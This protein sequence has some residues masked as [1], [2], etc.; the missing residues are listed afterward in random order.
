MGKL[1]TRLVLF[2]SCLILFC[3]TG[4][5]NLYPKE[6][7]TD[8]LVKLKRDGT[9]KIK[10]KELTT[11][12][13]G[14]ESLGSTSF[15][16]IKLNNR[17]S[18]DP[19]YKAEVT[20]PNADE[21][22]ATPVSSRQK[23]AE[24]LGD[25]NR[26]IEAVKSASQKVQELGSYKD[27][28]TRKE[29]ELPFGISREVGGKEYTIIIDSI[30]LTPRYAYA[31]IY[32]EIEDPENGKDLY[33]AARD[34]RFT[35]DGGF[36]G[37]AELYLLK[38]YKIDL[39]E[40][41]ALEF[42]SSVSRSCYVKFNCDGFQEL[43]VEA[44][45][46][47][48]P[49]HFIQEMPNSPSYPEGVSAN[50]KKK[51]D[52]RFKEI[53]N[54]SV[55]DDYPDDNDFVLNDLDT[56]KRQFSLDLVGFEDL[57][58]SIEDLPNF[59]VKGLKDF[60]FDVGT[61]VLDFSSYKHQENTGV[62]DDYDHPKL[63]AD[64]TLW[65]GVILTDLEVTLPDALNKNKEYSVGEKERIS[66]GVRGLIVDNLG[67]TGEV[68]GKN[69]IQAGE[70]DLEGWAF[71]LEELAVSFKHSQWKYA[72]FNGM[73][74][75]PITREGLDDFNYA[76]IISKDNGISLTVSTE[77]EVEFELFKAAEVKLDTNSSVTLTYQNRK[78]IPS[79]NLNG[80]F[81]IRTQVKKNED[82]NMDAEEGKGFKLPEVTF[83]NLTLTSQ[84]PF[85]T[86][87]TFGLGDA[88]SLAGLP[89]T[90]TKFE[91]KEAP[92]EKVA[93]NITLSVNLMKSDE[94]G[95][96]ASG[97]LDIVAGI[98]PNR[99]IA[100]YKLEEVR[101]NELELLADNK[102]F[103]LKGK[104]QFFRGDETYG[105][106]FNSELTLD[107]KKLEI[108]VDAKALFG[109]AK[110]TEGKGDVNEVYRYWYVDARAGFPPIML[111]P[112]ALG[113]N[114]FG[115]ALYHHMGIASEPVK[116]D[117]GQ[118]RTGI[119]YLPDSEKG[120]GVK[121]LIGIQGATKEAWSGDV[122]LELLFNKGGNGL[123]EILFSGY[124]GFAKTPQQ[125]ADSEE[126]KEAQKAKV[127]DF[128]Q[129]AAKT[130]K[131]KTMYSSSQN[132]TKI[133]E[134]LSQ[135]KV[136]VQWLMRFDFNNDVY[137][138]HADAYVNVSEKVKGA[139]DSYGRVGRLSYHFSDEHN[140]VWIGNPSSDKLSLKVNGWTADAY[141]V[142]GDTIPPVPEL[143]AD[144]IRIP[145]E[146]D[147][148]LGVKGALP[149]GGLAFGVRLTTPKE[150][151]KFLIFYAEIKASLG[152]DILLGNYS[153]YRCSHSGESP[154]INGWYASG[155]VYA[156]VN[157]QPGVRAK[158]FGEE[159]RLPIGDIV[160]SAVL[161]GKAPKPSYFAGFLSLNYNLLGGL[162]Q[163]E[164]DM[165]FAFGQTC[166]LIGNPLDNIEIITDIAPEGGDDVSVYAYPEVALA[167]PVNKVFELDNQETDE[168]GDKIKMR[169]SIVKFNLIDS[170]GRKESIVETILNESKDRVKIIPASVLKGEEKY[171]I[172]VE[173]A[174]ERFFS[175]GGW[176]KEG[177][178]YKTTSF[179]T[180]LEPGD[181]PLQL[182]SYSYPLPE[183]KN[184]YLDEFR[185]YG[186]L[187][188]KRQVRK[189][190]ILDDD[191]YWEK[192]WYLGE[193]II[194][195]SRGLSNIKLLPKEG[196]SNF[197]YSIP[198]DALK[199]NTSYSFVVVKV[200]KVKTKEAI[201]SVSYND[202]TYGNNQEDIDLDSLEKDIEV[203]Y[204]TT[205]K[206]NNLDGLTVN[207][208]E[209][210]ILRMPFRTSSHKTFKSHYNSFSQE[211][212]YMSTNGAM[213]QK[214]YNNQEN[215]SSAQ[216]NGFKYSN[217][218]DKYELVTAK[219]TD[220]LSSSYTRKYLNPVLYEQHWGKINRS[221]K[222]EYG[223]RNSRYIP[224]K[225]VRFHS[226]T[227]GKPKIFYTAGELV[228]IDYNRMRDEMIST[229]VNDLNR[230]KNAKPKLI[231]VDIEGLAGK[232]GESFSKSKFIQA[233]DS[234]TDFQHEQQWFRD[235]EK[236]NIGKILNEGYKVPYKGNYNA[237][238]SYRLPSDSYDR[239]RITSSVDQ[240]LTV[241]KSTE[242]YNN[243]KNYDKD[244]S[245]RNEALNKRNQTLDRLNYIRDQEDRSV[246]DKMN[247][248]KDKAKQWA[249]E[250]A[251]KA[252]EAARKAAQAVKNV[253]VKIFCWRRC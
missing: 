217:G 63:T 215:F 123:A 88:G 16:Y 209:V 28:L 22:E 121:A 179:K 195:K 97:D 106:G 75:T 196:Q 157:A 172:E 86:G 71:T 213:T 34:V 124:V 198:Y 162:V 77:K 143:S 13:I 230:A 119:T 5:S 201:S 148:S 216:L 221:N 92:D 79:A 235:V 94:S 138:G 62:F 27:K 253:V 140:Y 42:I 142:M 66:L 167:F 3:E 154:G 144:G 100:K 161:I 2:I 73:L 238:L 35:R 174:Y 91:M 173:V 252:A 205:I 211:K 177:D 134:V 200:P 103:K 219:A 146:V 4:L 6:V 54:R 240:R 38:N 207:A 218:N 152:F 204:E 118:T 122:A 197:T 36:S 99:R 236:R 223:E 111:V 170:K 232:L 59:Q 74:G 109:K 14:I 210:E 175:N 11:K 68:F 89:I 107:I 153:A 82:N 17:I 242:D 169:L 178:E 127:K 69:L 60:T 237:R 67:F 139:L 243:W 56:L 108:H 45:I 222:Y 189:P 133:G 61:L 53:S 191:F 202:V 120:L 227:Y 214:M 96:S 130:Q 234:R 24:V 159:R 165:K 93:L 18:Y 135:Y 208:D 156:F 70:T 104:L 150:A 51:I 25:A 55:N 224:Y 32:C 114:A 186:Y 8:P 48:S 249:R 64:S 117:Y 145:D 226:S 181:I 171:R 155:R 180:G 57:F 199:P 147:A 98:V 212:M 115:G 163:G 231:G 116:S 9:F 141:I 203:N 233:V 125:S 10:K 113:I 26:Y 7:L 52:E 239:S 39:G 188:L 158:V 248:V 166:E 168:I 192:R 50:D 21:P 229:I 30:V 31:V 76:G 80:S 81:T 149:D 225:Y 187:R 37:D 40:V 78:F 102:A 12:A 183:M 49:E 112:G 23:I 244:K 132:N 84:K 44:D 20:P 176:K 90:V 47:F 164:S 19:F 245:K 136:G 220:Y 85:I 246:K 46:W 151:K 194:Y 110:Y 15:S 182:I 41:A 128:G 184:F 87:G 72:R 101:V 43:H 33:F 241:S 193:K 247:A 131:G 58:I 190:L 83:Q 185:G 1:T 95:F 137:S 29:V 129:D 105:Q 206:T 251:E 160:A 228:Y 250:K 126:E 65:K